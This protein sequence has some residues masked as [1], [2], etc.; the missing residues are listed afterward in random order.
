MSDEVNKVN[1][2]LV[3]E[4]PLFIIYENSKGSIINAMVTF[5]LAIK[6]IFCIK[7]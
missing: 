6:I 1:N 2:H 7:L 4:L 5:P 3:N